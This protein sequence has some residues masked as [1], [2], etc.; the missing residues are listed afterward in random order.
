MTKPTNN[1][2]VSAWV[3][4]N[5]KKEQLRIEAAKRGMTLSRYCGLLLEKATNGYTD[6]D[7]T[8]HE[9]TFKTKPYKR[10]KKIE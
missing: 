4:D 8:G 7:I 3:T 6:F 5:D 1:P 9:E 10:R 2:V